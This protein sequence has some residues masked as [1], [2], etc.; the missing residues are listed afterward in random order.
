MNAP[1]GVTGCNFGVA[2]TGSCTLVSNEGNAR[3][4][5]SIPETQIVVMGTE[6]IVPDLLPRRNDETLGAQRCRCQD[7][8]FVLY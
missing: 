5:S 3:M 4:A 2:E 6:R 8:W 1:I 7:L